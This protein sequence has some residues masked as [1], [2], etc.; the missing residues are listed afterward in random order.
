MKIQELS[1]RNLRSIVD[2][3]NVPIQSLF[4]LVGENN[5]GKSNFIKSIEAFISGGAGGIK[6]EDFF[7]ASS[8]IVIKISF[9]NLTDDESKRWK[10]YLANGKLI[11]EKHIWIEEA[12]TASGFR[13]KSEY[14]GYEASPKE[15]FL[16]IDQILEQ[17]GQ[18]P[19]WAEIAI[20]NGLPDY[21]YPDD[22][23]NKMIYT[24][25]LEQYLLENDVEFNEPD[26]SE[27]HALGLQSNVVASLPSF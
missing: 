3:E 12:D 13:I 11:L 19:K 26:V 15:W 27:T 1:I 2:S 9:D 17:H 6:K 4:S 14:H 24:K 23:S 8:A 5:S 10:K 25:A 7:D 22:K 20:E 21:F 18:R 16:S